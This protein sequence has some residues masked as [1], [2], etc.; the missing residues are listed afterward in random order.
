MSERQAV[1]DEQIYF[2]KDGACKKLNSLISA[3]S[4][5]LR[6]G[7]SKNKASSSTLKYSQ[8]KE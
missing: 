6:E 2:A 7:G 5:K 4:Q 8:L 1:K 3:V